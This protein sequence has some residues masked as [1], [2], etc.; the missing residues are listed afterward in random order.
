MRKK[1]L[2]TGLL[3]GVLSLAGCG[4]SSGYE[5]RIKLLNSW[6]DSIGTIDVENGYKFDTYERTNEDDSRCS[7]TLYFKKDELRTE[8]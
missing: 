4:G 8:K 7:I 3:F 5:T 1:I 2:I 6:G